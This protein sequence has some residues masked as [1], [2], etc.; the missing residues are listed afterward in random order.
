M[1]RLLKADLY[2]IVKSK[3]FLAAAILSVA[4]PIFTVL[5]Y[6]VLDKVLAATTDLQAQLGLG[7]N[8]LNM[9]GQALISE[10]FV[11]SSNMG[12]ILPIFVTIF[13][14]TDI[15]SGTLRNKIIAGKSRATIYFSHLVSS[16]IVS[17]VLMFVNTLFFTLFTCL[18]FGYGLPIDDAEMIRL[19]YFFATGIFTYFFTASISTALTLSIKSAAPAVI[20]SSLLSMGLG[21]IASFVHSADPRFEN[22]ALCLIPS[23]TNTRFL[24]SAVPGA[25]D[26]EAFLLGILSYVVIGGLIS[27]A[28]LV[29]FSKKDIK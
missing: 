27:V 6:L 19:L 8:G 3:L 13:I 7:M 18:I 25:F 22:K 12:L 29:I 4:F 2:R 15:T 16:G 24:A 11:L 14:A 23:Y 20:F 21:M 5:I 9:T 1:A 26:L 17:A 10:A 28:G